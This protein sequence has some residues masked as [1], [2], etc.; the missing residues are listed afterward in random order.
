VVISADVV[1]PHED[2]DDL[3]YELLDSDIENE[4]TNAPIEQADVPDAPLAVRIMPEPCMKEHID[5]PRDI[6]ELYFSVI[7]NEGTGDCF[8][9]VILDSTWKKRNMP[10]MVQ[11]TFNC[12]VQIFKDL[13]NDMR[14]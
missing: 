9:Q 8:F 14:I 4:Q 6:T 11:T 13:R 1:F 2:H 10:S 5:L 7:D 3:Y 12:F